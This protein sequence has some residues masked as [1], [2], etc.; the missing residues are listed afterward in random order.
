MI[1]TEVWSAF[2]GNYQLLSNFL[3]QHNIINN[4]PRQPEYRDK[5]LNASVITEIIHPQFNRLAS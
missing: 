3:Y 5:N 1:I 2:S 4:L